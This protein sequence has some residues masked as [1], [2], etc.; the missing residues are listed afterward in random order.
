[1]KA[2]LLNKQYYYLGR[3]FYNRQIYCRRFCC[4]HFYSG[5]IAVWRFYSRRNNRMVTKCLLQFTLVQSLIRVSIRLNIAIVIESC[6]CALICLISYR[7]EN[8]NWFPPTFPFEFY[9]SWGIFQEFRLHLQV[10]KHQ[11]L[12]GKQ[13]VFIFSCQ[14]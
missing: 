3:H 5:K 11:M 10:T 2:L 13:L 6:I 12:R 8:S 7:Y 14:F 9:F 1:M 4:R